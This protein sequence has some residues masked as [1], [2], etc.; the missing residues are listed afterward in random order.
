MI[1]Q[2]AKNG[3]TNM[4][5]K[6]FDDKTPMPFGKYQGKAMANVPAQYLIWLIENNKA[7]GEL[8]KYIENNMEVLNKEIKK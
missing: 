7:H 3:N 2:N 1:S 8:R 6:P 4:L 5:Q